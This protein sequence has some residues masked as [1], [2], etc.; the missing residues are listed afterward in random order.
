MYWGGSSSPI[1]FVV[2]RYSR[3]WSGCRGHGTRQGARAG[4]RTTPTAPNRGCPPVMRSLLLALAAVAV[5][6]LPSSA[7]GVDPRLFVL[8]QIDVPARYE[9]DEDN[10]LLMPDRARLAGLPDESARVLVRLGFV[11]GFFARYTNYDP[12]RWRYVNS[13]ALRLSRRERGTRLHAVAGEVRV[14]AGKLAISGHRP[15]R[16]GPA[17]LLGLAVDRDGRRLAV[18][19]GRR[20]RGLFP[21]DSAPSARVGTRTK[22]AASHRRGASLDARRRRRSRRGCC[23]CSAGVCVSPRPAGARPSPVRRPRRVRRRPRTRVV[24]RRTATTPATDWASSWREPGESRA[25]AVSSGT[26]T[27]G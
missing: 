14:R 25:T 2:W 18:R 4:A 13:V 26:A 20:L 22:A 1:A 17:L 6:A 21:D 11:N 9:F 3:V 15:R 5:L 27:P 12:P 23:G 7:A 16:R 19:S 24:R 10:S 8:H